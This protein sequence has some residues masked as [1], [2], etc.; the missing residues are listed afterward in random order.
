MINLLWYYEE[1]QKVS[2]D[3]TDSEIKIR[4]MQW[5]T[6]TKDGDYSLKPDNQIPEE[7]CWLRTSESAD[8]TLFYIFL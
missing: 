4:E 6:E 2:E 1:E 8:S 3:L 7:N 5:V